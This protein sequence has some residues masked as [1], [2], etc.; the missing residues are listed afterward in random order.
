MESSDAVDELSVPTP[1]QAPDHAQAQAHAPVEPMPPSKKAVLA[2]RAFVVALSVDERAE[3]VRRVR[4]EAVTSEPVGKVRF[5][6]FRGVQ[7]DKKGAV[8]Q[9]RAYSPADLADMFRLEGGKV[10]TAKT[11]QDHICTGWSESGKRGADDIAETTLIPIDCDQGQSPDALLDLL[12]DMGMAYVAHDSYSHD[13]ERLGYHKWHALLFPTPGIR[14]S[15]VAADVV[16]RQYAYVV[17]VLAEMSASDGYDTSVGSRA[18]ILYVGN[19]PSK[20]APARRVWHRD[21]GGVV[22]RA[23]LSIFGYDAWEVA[24]A[25]AE[26]D[27]RARIDAARRISRALVPLPHSSDAG[28]HADLPKGE[29]LLRAFEEIGYLMGDSGRD[30]VSVR[31]PWAAEHTG[32]AQGR[33][34][35][36]VFA[37]G[38]RDGQGTFHCSHSHCEGRRAAAVWAWFRD[39]HPEVLVKYMPAP[40]RRPDIQDPGRVISDGDASSDSNPFSNLDLDAG[41]DRDREREADA[42]T[43]AAFLEGERDP[44]EPPPY[45]MPSELRALQESETPGWRTCFTEGEL[46]LK[47][48]GMPEK[49]LR[50]TVLFLSQYPLFRGALAYSRFSGRTFFT[51]EIRDGALRIAAGAEVT[52]TILCKLRVWFDINAGFEPGQDM[53][54]HAVTEAAD[55]NSRHEVQEYLNACRERYDGIQRLNDLGDYFGFKARH[56]DG[57]ETPEAKMFRKWILQAVA[58]IVRPG[59]Q[60]DYVIMFKGRQGLKKSTAL[61]AL[62]GDDWFSDSALPIGKT[63]GMAGLRGLWCIEIAEMASLEKVSDNERKAFI[64][65]KKDKFRSAYARRSETHDRQVVFAVT[66]NKDKPLTDDENRRYWVI[67]CQ[68]Y[69][70]P[71]DIAAIRDMIW[72]EAICCLEDQGEPAFFEPEEEKLVCLPGQNASLDAGGEMIEAYVDRFLRARVQ[73]EVVTDHNSGDQKTIDGVIAYMRKATQEGGFSAQDE[74]ATADRVRTFTAL[75]VATATHRAPDFAI[76]Y[77][78]KIGVALRARGLEALGACKQRHDGS[79]RTTRSYRIPWRWTDSDEMI[80]LADKLTA[81][82]LTLPGA[83]SEDVGHG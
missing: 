44:G 5:L 2:G 75:D 12:S 35:T 65:S 23:L 38:G 45:G 69:T 34:D 72:G 18:R 47:K 29:K 49:N 3:L 66:T 71:R 52:D 1:I 63:D 67:P 40:A 82:G 64:T 48:N 78:Q 27:E 31:C 51:R 57:R 60:A 37:H 55:R 30:K 77:G 6:H 8:G 76:R 32:G 10:Q 13:L 26:A 16:L 74:L 33:S 22:W 24:R 58:R 59:C 7:H 80:E 70:R 79:R 53:I 61:R 11:R 25:K 46:R 14:S 39:N 68:T 20:T 43:W 56:E 73:G 19:R 28:I 21:G 42:T 36:I 50:N 15:D 83:V 9:V 41:L 4:A 54:D 62:F 81:M 17:G